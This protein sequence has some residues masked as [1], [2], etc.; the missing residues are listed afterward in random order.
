MDLKKKLTKA[1]G[2]ARIIKKFPNDVNKQRNTK[3]IHKIAAI[4]LV[5]ISFRIENFFTCIRKLHYYV[6]IK[7]ILYGKK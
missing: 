7:H 2:E 5:D 1:N 6:H 3:I 4:F